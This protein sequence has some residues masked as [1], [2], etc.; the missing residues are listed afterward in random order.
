MAGLLRKSI[1]PF[2][3]KK[4][5]HRGRP[6]RRPDMHRDQAEVPGAAVAPG[7][8]WAAVILRRRSGCRCAP[9]AS[10]PRTGGCRAR[11]RCVR[12]EG[13]RWVQTLKGA[14]TG[15]SGWSTRCY[16]WRWARGASAD[17]SLRHIAGRRRVAPRRSATTACC[18]R[19][20]APRSRASQHLLRASGCVVELAF[21]RGAGG[22]LT[23]ALAAV[24][25]EMELKGGDAGAGRAGCALGDAFDL[26]AGHA[27]A[28]PNGERPRAAAASGRRFGRQPM[29][30]LTGWTA[31]AAVAPL[32]ELPAPGAGQRLRTGARA[33]PTL[34]PSLRVGLHRARHH[35]HRARRDL[36]PW[37]P[38]RRTRPGTRR[39]R[40]GAKRPCS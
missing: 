2:W 11:P 14:A 31:A 6:P 9:A 20:T 21:D 29:V 15:C 12:K 19:S 30:R 27:A 1:A 36:G 35:R 32:G 8:C 38:G 40:S 13:W 26:T 4:G 39:C 3:R 16:C 34:A 25:L 33:E 5:V 28:R 10:T 23:S 37:R 7:R 17:P 22:R 24:R 18:S